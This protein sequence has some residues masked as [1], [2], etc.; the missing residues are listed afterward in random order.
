[1]VRERCGM[2]LYLRSSLFLSSYSLVVSTSGS[3][4]M[5][6]ISPSSASSRMK[7]SA[8]TSRVTLVARN[9]NERPMRETIETTRMPRMNSVAMRRPSGRSMM[10]SIVV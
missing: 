6:R 10:L 1:M 9:W 8:V 5:M 4:E 7:S 3:C 2:W